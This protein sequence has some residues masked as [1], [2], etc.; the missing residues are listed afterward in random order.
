MGQS[1]PRGVDVPAQTLTAKADSVLVAPVI[2]STAHSKSTG[3][4]PAAWTGD[5]PLRTVTGSPDHA[6]VAPFLK[7]RY[8]EREG[9]APRVASVEGLM[10]TVVPSANGGD[11]VAAFLAQHNG[12][13]N[14]DGYTGRAAEEPLSTT[15]A[16]GTQQQL[17]AAH[18]L[19]L[20]GSDRRA[21]PADAPAAT[22]TGGGMHLAEVRAFLL[23]YYGE[24]SVDQDCREPL[25]TVPT[26]GRFGLVTIE[27]QDW[28]IVDIGMRMLTPRELFRAQGFPDSYVIDRRPDGTP[29]TKTAQIKACGNSVCPPVAAA[30]VA[31]NLA[32]RSAASE[33]PATANP[34]A[35]SSSTGCPTT[36]SP[37]PSDHPLPA[38]A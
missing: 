5:E 18:L 31:A 27:G 12:G 22:I 17:V 8:G 29:L 2:A 19:N 4:G 25:H 16:R 3:R 33:A 38:T 15:T 10:P 7:P 24:G 14:N 30:L 21:G 11:L 13:P 36:R 23:K 6:V 34:T 20:K 26:K 32:G 1:P 28:Q 35:A 9:Q 37:R